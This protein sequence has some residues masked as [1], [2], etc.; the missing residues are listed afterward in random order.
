MKSLPLL[1]TESAALDGASAVPTSSGVRTSA[2][3]LGVALRGG[4]RDR[5]LALTDRQLALVIGGV[6][7]VAGAWPLAL[8]SVPPFQDLP[9]HLATVEVIGNLK[10][11]PEYAF[12]GFFKTNAALFTW[13]F[14]V[15]KVVGMKMAARLFALLVLGL[16]AFVIPRFVLDL[17]KSRARMLVASCLRVAD[18]SQLVRV[19]GHARLRPRPA[20]LARVARLRRPAT[21]CAIEARTSR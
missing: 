10:A 19:D 1:E 21:Q 13:L 9:N 3:D 2:V 7:F 5:A 16:N 6:L 18:D 20:A 15:G 4:L 17:T 14:V 8:T 12:N 11:Y